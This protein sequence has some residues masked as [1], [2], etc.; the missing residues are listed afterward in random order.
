LLGGERLRIL[1][2]VEM[3]R[4]SHIEVVVDQTRSKLTPRVSGSAVCVMEGHIEA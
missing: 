3:K 2:G 1:Q 4:P